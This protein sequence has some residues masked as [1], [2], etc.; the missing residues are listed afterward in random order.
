MNSDDE[1]R[2]FEQWGWTYDQIA[3]AYISPDG[4]QRVAT[5]DLVTAADVMGPGMELR[6]REIAS[7][8]GVRR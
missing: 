7:K 4:G 6:V 2:I 3:R 1:R 8:F 5:D